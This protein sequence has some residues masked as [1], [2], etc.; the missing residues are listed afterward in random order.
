MSALACGTVCSRWICLWVSIVATQIAGWA[1]VGSQYKPGE[2]G[3]SEWA[4]IQQS[5]PWAVDAWGMGCLM[6]E[7]FSAKELMRTE[8]LRNTDTIPPPLLQVGLPA[9]LF[10]H[11]SCHRGTGTKLFLCRRESWNL[12]E[13]AEAKASTSRSE[14][15][16]MRAPACACMFVRV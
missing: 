3:K 10:H 5:P 13:V 14:V 12:G 7:A 11:P 16:G 6:Q 9:V 1:Q 2:V 15:I 4:A 8:D